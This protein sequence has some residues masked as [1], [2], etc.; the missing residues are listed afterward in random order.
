MCGP[1]DSSG[2]FKEYETTYGTNTYNEYNGAVEKV[3]IVKEGSKYIAEGKPYDWY[4]ENTF[5]KE[6]SKY[7]DS[8]KSVY[9]VGGE[10][11]IIYEHYNFL[12]ECIKDGYSKGMTIEYNTN[13]TVIPERAIKLWK[14]F[15]QVKFGVSI[16]GVGKVNDYIRWPS[17]FSTI[18]K[19][20]R[21]LDEVE[22]NYILWTSYTVSV[23][24]MLHLPEFIIW[25]IRQKFKRVN[26]S[27]YDPFMSMHPLHRP[28]CM[29]I[30]IFP[31]ESA[32]VIGKHLR[33]SVQ[34]VAN[35]L[36]KSDVS[37]LERE[38]KNYSGIV[39]GYI[40]YMNQEDFSKFIPEFWSRNNKID[41]IRGCDLRDYIPEII[42]LLPMGN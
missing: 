7:K 30:K 18:E 10:P 5:W 1:T 25:K 3:K 40:K 15:D 16:D 34:R 29:N 22:S 21:L 28:D 27:P 37:N 8:M 42:D 23:Y 39:E 36:A 19:N 12:D 2:W 24:N 32:E 6:L 26:P 20:L 41:E 31:K 14:N 35:E 17:K 38:V 13:L 11:L 4:K 9:I 33:E